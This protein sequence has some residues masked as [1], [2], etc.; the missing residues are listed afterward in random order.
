MNRSLPATPVSRRLARRHADAA[1][2][3]LTLDDEALARMFASARFGTI[4]HCDAIPAVDGLYEIACDRGR[5]CYVLLSTAQLAKGAADVARVAGMIQ[6]LII[7][8]DGDPDGPTRSVLVTPRDPAV[9]LRRAHLA[10]GERARRVQAWI[11][12]SNVQWA[13]LAIACPPFRRELARRNGESERDVYQRAFKVAQFR[14]PTFLTELLPY[15]RSAYAEALD[16]VIARAPEHAREY[17]R[18]V[19]R[20][21]L[22]GER[23]YGDHQAVDTPSTLPAEHASAVRRAVDEAIAAERVAHLTAGDEVRVEC[24]DDG[25]IRDGVIVEVQPQLGGA[26]IVEVDYPADHVAPQG[27]AVAN[28]VGYTLDRIHEPPS[29]LLLLAVVAANEPAEPRRFS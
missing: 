9:A 1:A 26:V 12:D 2:T 3:L 8:V 19:V 16:N 10:H 27:K 23:G 20:A 5:H 24:F 6:Q 29:P 17:A 14:N 7:T 22:T 4:E 25:A 18:E 15:P 13:T 28:T 21:T 11:A